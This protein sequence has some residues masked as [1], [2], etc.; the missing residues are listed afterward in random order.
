MPSISLPFVCLL[1]FLINSVID[2]LNLIPGV[3]INNIALPFC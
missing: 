2:L 1:N 3:G